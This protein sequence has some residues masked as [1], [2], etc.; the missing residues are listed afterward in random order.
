MVHKPLG[1]SLDGRFVKVRQ[2]DLFFNILS[3]MRPGE[4]ILRDLFVGHPV[5]TCSGVELHSKGIAAN[6]ES[7]NRKVLAS[8]QKHSRSTAPGGHLMTPSQWAW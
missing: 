2:T 1:P 5:E 8:S 3:T 4:G 6:A 7:L